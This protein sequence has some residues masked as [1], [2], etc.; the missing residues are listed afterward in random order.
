MQGLMSVSKNAKQRFP[1]KNAD[2]GQGFTPVSPAA[3]VVQSHAVVPVCRTFHGCI[4]HVRCLSLG[5]RWKLAYALRCEVD[6]VPRRL[7]RLVQ[8]GQHVRA[9]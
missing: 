1:A 9:D 7:F 2:L 6:E 4:E 3:D 8:G 5:D